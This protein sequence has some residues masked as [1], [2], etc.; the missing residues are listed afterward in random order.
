[1]RLGRATACPRRALGA[2]IE[3]RNEAGHEG[4]GRTGQRQG[5][6]IEM[7]VLSRALPPEHDVDP[8]EHEFGLRPRELAD[9]LCEQVRVQ[10]QN[11]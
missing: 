11:L 4:G 2:A 10:R 8:R 1:M 6:R 9:A 3:G 7:G 5:R